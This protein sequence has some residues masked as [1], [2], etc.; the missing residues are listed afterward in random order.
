MEMNLHD[1]RTNGSTD[2]SHDDADKAQLIRDKMGKMGIVAISHIVRLHGIP[3]M[4]RIRRKKY[5]GCDWV[6][7]GFHCYAFSTH[8][9]RLS[10]STVLQHSRKCPILVLLNRHW[11]EHFWIGKR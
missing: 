7:P 8:Y 9:P 11:I 1:E 5:L 6:T 2:Q 4:E 3:C 10:K